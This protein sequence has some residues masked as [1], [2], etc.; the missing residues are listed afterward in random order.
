MA[1]SLLVTAILISLGVWQLGRA[2]EKRAIETALKERSA[3]APLRVGKDRLQLPE[4]EYRQGVAQGR[5]DGS[6]IIF[7]DNQIHEGQAGYHVLVP[8]RLTDR[9]ES[10]ILVN[11][12]WTPMGLDRQQ[13]PAVDPPQ[14]QLT[15]RGT[16]R[17][18]PQAPFFLGDE[19]SRESSGW[20]KRV[21][22]VSTEQLQSQLG[23]SLQPLVLQLA[24]D[25]PYGFLRQWP[26]LPT[27][28]QQHVAYA[29]Q[30][31]ALALIAGVVFVILYR[32]SFAGSAPGNRDERVKSSGG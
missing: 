18:P 8:L 28:V 10:A 11:L 23:Y 17:R 2:D 25:G 32:R 6:H 9:E 31:F 5:F 24:P 1:V 30:W 15:V 26:G 12:G 22:Y 4:S 21:Q 27:S 16:L 20:P 13:L 7:L 3:S 14:S 19:E 29:V